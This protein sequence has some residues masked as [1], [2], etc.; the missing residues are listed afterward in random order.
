MEDNNEIMSQTKGH[1]VSVSDVNEYKPG[2]RVLDFRLRT[3]ESY[4]QVLEFTLYDKGIDKLGDKIEEGSQ[5]FIKY[6]VKGREW[7]ER[8]YHTLQPWSMRVIETIADPEPEVEHD[9]DLDE[10]VPF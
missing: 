7:N 9:V 8:Y 3:D 1:I 2:K 4:P 10:D 5:V 6:N